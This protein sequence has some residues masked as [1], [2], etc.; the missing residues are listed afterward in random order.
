[1]QKPVA[2]PPM[3][4]RA[5]EKLPASL[6]GQLPSPPAARPA[7]RRR[8]FIYDTMLMSLC[9]SLGMGSLFV[10]VSVVSLVVAE[11][12]NPGLALVPP[13]VQKLVATFIAY[14]GARHRDRMGFTIAAACGCLGYLIAASAVVFVDGGM[15]SFLLLCFGYCVSGVSDPFT[16]FLR[17]AS[18]DI[19]PTKSKPTAISYVI[20][21]GALAAFLGPEL[22]NA[23]VDSIPG[24]RYSGAYLSASLLLLA[25]A[26]ILCALI[27]YTPDAADKKVPSSNEPETPSRQEAATQASGDK[28]AARTLRSIMME[29]TFLL[30]VSTAAT[31]QLTMISLMQII[32]IT[33]DRSGFELFHSVKVIQGHILGM[34]LPS[35]FTGGLIDRLGKHAMMLTGTTLNL[36]AALCLLIDTSNFWSYFV[37]LTAIGVGWNWGFVSA[38]AL[39]TEHTDSYSKA[40]KARARGSNDLSV[41]LLGT[42]GTAATGFAAEAFGWPALA[43]IN[44]ALIAMVLALIL[45]IMCRENGARWQ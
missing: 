21:G 20:A 10:S 45:Y 34:Y 31:L 4:L 39:L 44:A 18:S 7:R 26:L 17:F 36:I 1:M 27:D 25:M 38:T 29:P 35:F 19:A 8:P 11:R 37:C 16:Q 23:T 41:Q 43:V 30:A 12:V 3:P 33:M 5:V 28:A 42:V 32:P 6:D 22:A 2:Q 24:S 13:A 15:A 40:D 14:P 9:Y